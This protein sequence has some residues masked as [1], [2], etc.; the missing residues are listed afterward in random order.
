VPKRVAIIDI[1]SNSARLVI[2]Q[3]TSRFGFHL[4]HQQ[5]SS[6]RISE[7]TYENSGFLQP[8][9]I[10][11]AYSLISLFAQTL[12]EYKVKKLL[13][14]ATSAVREAPNKSEFISL[15]KRDFGIKIKVISG[16][17]EAFLSAFGAKNLLPI[18]D[19]IT[20][21]IGGGSADLALI[22]NCQIKAIASLKLG[23]IRIKELFFDKKIS[24]KE[25]KEYINKELEKIPST[26]FNKTDIAITIGGTARAIA[27]VIMK[28]EKYPFDKIHA[29]TYDIKKST[30]LLEKIIFSSKKELKKLGVKEA[31]LDT[32]REGTL[33]FLEI[34]N[35][36]KLKKSVVSGVGLREG[37]FLNDLLRN[38]NGRFPA[39]FNP[40]I[41]SIID[42]FDVLKL[43]K[44]NKF[45]IAKELYSILEDKISSPTKY[46]KYINDALKLSDIG[47]ILTIYKEHQHAYYI[48]AQELNYGY[49]HSEILLISFILRSKGEKLIN[50]TLYKKYKSLLPPKKILKWLSFIYTLTLILHENSAKSKYSFKIENNTLIIITP[51]D[52]YIIKE[53]IKK[54]KK[55]KEIKVKILNS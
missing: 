1:G 23:T 18:K 22:E 48:A 3:R 45:K 55:P 21:D 34:F 52:E 38:T 7:G 32:I 50:K 42:R 44:G 27:K 54:L 51:I 41:R 29:F 6:I 2:Y 16:E 31:R 47:K 35:Y 33:I 53:E 37:L 49:W 30:P 26:F 12:K 5:K 4:I 24:T 28:N 43:P 40:S 9:A 17:K 15:I 36:L 25:A 46:Y 39:N 19:G 13:A 11:R 10:K 8:Q 14:V 20:I